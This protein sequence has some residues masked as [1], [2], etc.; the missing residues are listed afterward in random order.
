MALRYPDKVGASIAF[1]P[2]IA[3]MIY[4]GADVLLMPSR[5]EPCGLAQMIA[6]HYG[7][8]PIVRKTGGLA[9]TI[10]DCRLGDGNGFV[11]EEYTSRALMSTIK[12]A[13]ELYTNQREDWENLMREAMNFDFGWKSS[14]K[15]YADLY[16]ELEG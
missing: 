16:R 15:A 1:N 3:G 7:T 13:Y 9:D 10:Q 6:C 2:E 4:A 11:F 12:S 8:I 5:S 14:A